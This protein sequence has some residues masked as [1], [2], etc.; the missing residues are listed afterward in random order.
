MGD[1]WND[2]VG[3]PPSPAA[4]VVFEKVGY[5]L[6]SQNN[7]EEL[8]SRCDALSH[9]KP[10][11][12]VEAF[13]TTT[14]A[15]ILKR[16]RATGNDPRTLDAHREF[17]RRLA[18]RRTRDTR[19]KLFTTNYDRCFELAAA[20]LGLVPI[21]GFSFAMPRRFNPQFFE[22]DI[23]HRAAGAEVSSFVPGVFL[24][25]KLHGSVDWTIEG[26]SIRSG[27]EPTADTACLIYPASTK[28]QRSF[29]QPHLELM[30]QYLSGLRQSSTC[31]IV[32]GFGF[33][34]DHLCEPILSALESNPHFRLIVVDPAAETKFNASEAGPNW[35]RLARLSADADVA[36]IR[37][38]FA[39]FVS[40]IPDLRALTPPERLAGAVRAVVGERPA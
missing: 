27:G 7:I 19:L 10:D 28:Y 6:G 3:Y 17:L 29:Q 22:Y 30:A 21:D 13:R 16:C 4:K 11:R 12:E 32:V 31:L 40:L 18:R 1:L 24:Y 39:Q 26:T 25:L 2:A 34:D 37:A 14:L 15:M 35:K 38:E 20:E 36:L 23:V 33:N 9:V 8:L 5:K